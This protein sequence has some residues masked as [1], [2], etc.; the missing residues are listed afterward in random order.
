MSDDRIMTLHP[1]GKQGVHIERD[2]YDDMRQALEKVIPATDEGLASK[3]LPIL[4]VPLLNGALWRDASIV[5]F[6]V[7]VKQDLE[8]REVIEQ[9]AKKKPQHVRRTGA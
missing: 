1:E 8:A 7:T 5:W 9:V 3:D 4:V 2:K 6:V